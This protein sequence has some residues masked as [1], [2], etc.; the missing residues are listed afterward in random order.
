MT[1]TR[2]L[3][4]WTIKLPHPDSQSGASIVITW[5]AAD[6]SQS[7]ILLM[8]CHTVTTLCNLFSDAGQSGSILSVLCLTWKMTEIQRFYRDKTVFIT[9]GTGFIGKI[10]IEKLLRWGWEI[11]PLAL[12][13]KYF[14]L[15]RCQDNLHVDQTEERGW[16]S[17][18]TPAVVQI[19]I[20]WH[21]EEAEAP[22]LDKGRV[23]ITI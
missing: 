12:L 9:G 16:S 14:Q 1:F 11:F 22:K 23:S 17:R 21:I 18:E 2:D 20:V 10:I 8:S 6:Q 15:H 13:T 3:A 4:T 19:S 5:L 7:S